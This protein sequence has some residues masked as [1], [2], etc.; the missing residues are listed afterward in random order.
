LKKGK[1]MSEKKKVDKRELD[2]VLFWG[3]PVPIVKVNS[4]A[5][6]FYRGV[7]RIIRVEE[8]EK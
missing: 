7:P 5:P 6:Q 3:C 8:E 1:K 4:A 2:A